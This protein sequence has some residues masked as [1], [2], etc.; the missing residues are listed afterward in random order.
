MEASDPIMQWSITL[1]RAMG[2]LG[3]DV[4]VHAGE[5]LNFRI[6]RKEL[7]NTAARIAGHPEVALAAIDDLGL[8]NIN[9][10]PQASRAYHAALAQLMQA[11]AERGGCIIIGRAG[12]AILKDSPHTLHVRITA[13]LALR[14][15]RVAARLGISH[16]AA[17]EQV[18]S[19]DHTRSYYLRRYYHRRWDDPDQYDLVLNTDRLTAVQAA[20]MLCAA[21]QARA[22]SS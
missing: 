12:Q 6:V 18:K 2:S 20:G 5:Q 22:R 17:Q 15:E 9:P 11:E 21:L 16:E 4:A 10:S 14:I 8:L 3:E 19:T 13:P 1:S 7:I